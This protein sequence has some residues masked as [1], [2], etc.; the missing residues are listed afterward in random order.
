MQA[1]S[2]HYVRNNPHDRSFAVFVQLRASV[3]PP[4][5]RLFVQELGRRDPDR[6][7]VHAPCGETDVTKPN[8][9]RGR[10]LYSDGHGTGCRRTIRSPPHFT[11]RDTARAPRL[12]AA[13]E[14]VAFARENDRAFRSEHSDPR[15]D[16]GA[17]EKEVVAIR[18]TAV[19][20]GFAAVKAHWCSRISC[21]CSCS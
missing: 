4:V 20:V 1:S 19:T 16:A 14:R 21:S 17:A 3:C 5:T 15:R 12:R 11:R 2:P 7:L 10:V 8:H 13:A 9:C 6:D 18:G